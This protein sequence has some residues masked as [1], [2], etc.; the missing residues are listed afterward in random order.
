MTVD[1][2]EGVCGMLAGGGQLAM[3]GPETTCSNGPMASVWGRGTVRN[4]RKYV[5]L[6]VFLKFSF[7]I[8]Y[9]VKFFVCLMIFLIFA[10][11][12][13]EGCANGRGGRASEGAAAGEAEASLN[14]GH[15]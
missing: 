1:G 10:S 13:Q 7:E 4:S 2:E 14:S 8:I 6:N 12:G 5:W 15:K 3:D 11:A 9:V